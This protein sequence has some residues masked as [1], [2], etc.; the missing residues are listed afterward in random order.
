MGFWWCVVPILIFSSNN[1]WSEVLSLNE[2]NFQ[3]TLMNNDFVLVN[4]YAE[5][6]RFS[7]ELTPVFEKASNSVATGFPNTNVILARVDCELQGALCLQQGVSKYPTL[8]LFKYGV[9]YRSEYRNQRSVEAFL[10]YLEEQT[11]NP[12]SKHTAG[13]SLAGLKTKRSMVGTFPAFSH[14][15]PVYDIFFKMAHHL[16]DCTCYAIEDNTKGISEFKFVLKPTL[17][18]KMDHQEQLGENNEQIALTEKYPPQE[19]LTDLNK[20][21]EWAD[22]V[23]TPYVR[24][25]TF[26]NAEEIT[27]PRLP[28]LILFYPPGD[29]DN[30]SN[31]YVHNFTTLMEQHL[32]NY[33]KKIVPLIADGDVFSHPLHHLG[34]T[35]KDLPII[36]IDSFQHMFPYPGDI[37][38]ALEDPR[39]INNF[40][41]DLLSNKL[42]RQFHGVP[43]PDVEKTSVPQQ[44]DDG[45][46]EAPRESVFKLLIP[47]RNRY[48]IL[49]D[50]L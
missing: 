12:L 24:E 36:A 30:G 17:D 10:K 23:C 49:K 5:W 26:A 45:D 19:I 13:L 41:L 7:L 39:H 50:E 16:T 9:R 2:D 44:N 32:T 8:K 40:L 37:K 25:L 11:A 42:H 31:S 38:A 46:K 35:V 27:E 28:L 4:F 48:S 1:A 43:E 47:S 21:I 33:S 34:K 6:C 3:N 15:N 18:S 14:D 29:K 20:L 22:E